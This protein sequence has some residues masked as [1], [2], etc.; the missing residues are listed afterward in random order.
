MPAPNDLTD[1]DP[2][3]RMDML[4]C[5]LAG[6]FSVDGSASNANAG[7]YA[8]G[9]AT[10][11]CGPY[12][13]A[14]LT[15]PAPTTLEPQLKWVRN[16]ADLRFDRIAEINL[17]I[18]DMLS[19]FGAISQLD[20]SARRRSMEVMMVTLRLAYML[21]MR[22]KSLTW[23]PRPIDMST[24]VQPMIQTPDHSSFP[25]GQA[26]EAFA[27][28]TVLTRMRDPSRS[29]IAGL[30]AQDQVFQLAHRIAVNR[31]IA[32]VHFPLDNSAGARLG[33]AIGEAIWALLARTN[34]SFQVKTPLPGGDFILSE[35]ELDEF[36]NRPQV[37]GRR[38]ACAEYAAKLSSEWGH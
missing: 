23:A 1:L 33:C 31:T 17:Q 12:P 26:T 7:E 18:D 21:V 19:F 36:A 25:G 5:E 16:Y 29:A 30:A 32:G 8:P 34:V 37:A 9:T 11:S 28:A 20:A 3:R 2:S 38:F 4:L 10:L 35:V 27:L 22:I 13:I 15:A 6:E 24:R 14:T